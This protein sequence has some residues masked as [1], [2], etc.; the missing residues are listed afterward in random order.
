[1]TK[2]RDNFLKN[3]KLPKSYLDILSGYHFEN[4][5]YESEL[6]NQ[7]TLSSILKTESELVFKEII[8]FFNLDKLFLI[9]FLP[10]QCKG[11]VSNYIYSRNIKS[12]TIMFPHIEKLGNLIELDSGYIKNIN[13]VVLS[14]D[15]MYK[16]MIVYKNV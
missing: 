13:G 4:I 12:L 10:L 9:S 16:E 5:F 6:I 8:D 7:A 1:M 11:D 2:A 15:N 3:F 14:L